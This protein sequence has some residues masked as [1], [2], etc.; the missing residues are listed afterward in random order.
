M[1]LIP[2][3]TAGL[4]ISLAACGGGSSTSS[5]SSS[6]S[7]V[8]SS[9]VSSA[10]SSSESSAEASSSLSSVETSSDVSSQASSD[11][12]SSSQESSSNS[13]AEESSSSVSSLANIWSVYN[14]VNHPMTNGALS[15]ADASAAEFAQTGNGDYFSALNNGTVALDTSADT[16]FTSGASFYNVVNTDAVYPKTLTLLQVCAAIATTCACWN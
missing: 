8:V 14:G 5:S 3:L 4:A 15:L 16:S 1:K 7:S 13:S 10:I 9:V 2:L 6:T 11:E 12:Q